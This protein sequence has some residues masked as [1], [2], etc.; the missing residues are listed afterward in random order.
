MAETRPTATPSQPPTDVRKYDYR[1][2][3]EFAAGV[4]ED[5]EGLHRA[6]CRDLSRHLSQLLQVSVSVKHRSTDEVPYISYVRSL[7]SPTVLGV[8]GLMPT[9]GRVVLDLPNH[10]GFAALDVLLGGSGRPTRF[11][12]MTDLE[13]SIL[14][15]VLNP[16]AAGINAAF[17]PI[18]ALGAELQAIQT[19]PSVAGL[20]EPEEPTLVMS[21][22][23]RIETLQ[24]TEGILSLCYSRSALEPLLAPG[25]DEEI[26]IAVQAP[27]NPE[28]FD[29]LSAVPIDVVARLNASPI[30]LLELSELQPGDV[31]LLS[32]KS[33]QPVTVSAG[34]HELLEANVGQYNN[35]VALSVTKWVM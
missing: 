1:G 18:A 30:S 24:P 35:N 19:H 17:E 16:V 15:M 32:H 28:L 2:G 33:N 13:G 23:V 14:T 5:L 27:V 10:L 20:F 12:P 6:F 29:P 31:V 7:P 34:G 11:R 4:V 3:S 8:I 26:E 25:L 21:F 22:D 9:S